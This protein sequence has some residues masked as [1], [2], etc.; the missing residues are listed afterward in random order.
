MGSDVEIEQVIQHQ[1]TRISEL[2]IQVHK[3]EEKMRERE[4]WFILK[5]GRLTIRWPN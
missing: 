2:Q 5:V 3:L 4:C 1:K